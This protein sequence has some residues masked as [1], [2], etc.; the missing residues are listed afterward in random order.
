MENGFQIV[1]ILSGSRTTILTTQG[2]T[3]AVFS[4]NHDRIFFIQTIPGGG[5]E[6][7]T[8]FTNGTGIQSLFKAPN[9]FYALSDVTKD[10]GNILLTHCKVGND[11]ES[12]SCF[13]A[14]YNFIT[15]KLQW[16]LLAGNRV[17]G[18]HASFNG[19][20]T[21]ITFIRLDEDEKNDVFISDWIGSV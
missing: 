5:S 18:T 4:P 8:A 7:V 2:V 14:T 6:L 10:G 1:D 13:L 12:D 21:K 9:E 15:T 3:S 20:G 17:Q 11:D 16:V 19:D